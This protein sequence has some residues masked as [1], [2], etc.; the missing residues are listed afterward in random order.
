MRQ[1]HLALHGKTPMIDFDIICTRK[2]NGKI[3]NRA[4]Y[5]YPYLSFHE[6]VDFD[7]IRTRKFKGKIFN[8]AL[9]HY[10]FYLAFHECVYHLASI[11]LC[12]AE[13]NIKIF[14]IVFIYSIVEYESKFKSY[15]SNF[16]SNTNLYF[17]III[18]S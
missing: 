8:R 4:L 2:F 17:R 6:C 15:L 14:V 10:P 12:R 1:Q 5:H 18:K 16:R 9:S 11:L 13:S 7:I 3:L